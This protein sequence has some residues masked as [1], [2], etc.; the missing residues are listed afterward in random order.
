M[1]ITLL[2][3]MIIKK[4]VYEMQTRI[5]DITEEIYEAFHTSDYIILTKSNGQVVGYVKMA[6]LLKVINLGTQLGW[7]L[8]SIMEHSFTTVKQNQS[9]LLPYIKEDNIIIVVDNNDKPLGIIN[10]LVF[11]KKKLKEKKPQFFNINEVFI[12]KSN[13]GFLVIESTNRIITY[14]TMFESFIGTKQSLI[15]KDLKNLLPNIDIEQIK[16]KNGKFQTI[17]NGK[18]L[19]WHFYPVDET[20]QGDEYAF[21]TICIYDITEFRQAQEEI[22][23]LKEDNKNLQ[24]IIDH[25]YDEIFVTNEK[26]ICTMV[27][28]ACE[29]IYG[30][31]KEEMIGKTTQQL[32]DEGIVSSNIS[33]KAIKEKRRITSIQ[34]TSTGR[35]IIVT[36]NPVFNSKKKVSK[37]II[38]AREI[39][40]LSNIMSQRQGT[41]N[42]GEEEDIPRMSLLSKDTIFESSR[43][44]KILKTAQKVSHVDSTVLMLG[45]SGVG[46][47]VIAKLIHKLSTRKKAEYI[48]VNC[49][50]IPESLIE[51]ELFGYEEGAFTGARKEG[52]KG[53]FELAHQGTIFLDEVG[54]IPLHLQSKLLQAI[55]EKTIMR[56]GGKKNIYINCRIIAATNRNLEQMIKEGEFREDLYYRLNVIPINIPSLR[57]RKTDIP[58]LIQH[59]IDIFNERFQENK[60][61]SSEAMETLVNYHWPGNI[62]ELENLIERLV[63]TSSSRIIRNGDLEENINLNMF[64][65]ENIPPKQ[66][67]M[68]LKESMEKLEK[69]IIQDAIREYKTTYHAA[70]VLQVAQSTI[71]RKM[72]KYNIHA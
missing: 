53:L 23:K 66:I 39:T 52:K 18:H 3:E 48:T 21:T 13:F 68:P 70:E 27:N 22:M 20:T 25:S 24:D 36:A 37:I 64:E 19:E 43:M 41:F 40:E 63:V 56:V 42:H 10:K 57:E 51:S 32:K 17:I 30:V 33:N 16:E 55:Q 4:P 46:K 5:R 58:I 61:L 7:R 8:E 71:V 12:E 34:T 2:E 15:G 49:S 59:F 28:Q 47:G 9:H 6:Y 14:N 44:K 50:A 65:A 31:P 62:R 69:Q 67:T 11:L 45:E 29:R 38:N 35:K 26:G 60:E 54:E 72:K 1:I